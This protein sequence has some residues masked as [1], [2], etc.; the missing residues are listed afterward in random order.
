MNK[1]VGY[2]NQDNHNRNNKIRNHRKVVEI[3]NRSLVII[4]K[5]GI[6][7]RNRIVE[8]WL[9]KKIVIIIKMEYKF[10]VVEVCR[11]TG[12]RIKR[13]KFKDNSSINHY[14]HWLHNWISKIELLYKIV[15]YYISLCQY[16]LIAI[17]FTS[18]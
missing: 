6:W 14:Q 17:Y 16:K 13:M 4:V 15:L 10:M 7:V 1:V 3:I 18:L 8:I 12:N 9:S 2:H 11:E 5:V